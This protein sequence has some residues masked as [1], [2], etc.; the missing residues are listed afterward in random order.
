MPWIVGGAAIVGGLLGSNAT[1]SA[2]SGQADA[3]RAAT[4]EQR[5]QFDLTR[6]DTRPYRETGAAALADLAGLRGQEPSTDA[7]SVMREPGYQLGLQQGRGALEG[8]AAAR[9]GL[10]SGQALREL[11]QFGN[12]YG[13][14]KFNDSFNRQQT[15]F[16][17]R[18]NRL[19]GLAGIGQSGVNQSAAAG[20]NY[21]NQA[22]AIG[23]SNANAQGA[24]GIAQANIWGST[25][26]QL[27]SLAGRGGWGSGG[28][29]GGGVPSYAPSANYGG[30]GAWWDN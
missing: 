15:A 23:M 28:G 20:Q 12:D 30:D 10:Y 17:N 22:G 14:T 18:W 27:A 21:A 19:A 26:N 9:G 11:T 8:S 5:R 16:G 1:R 2:A 4:E 6:E 13:T 29:G 25:A 7:A 3:A 24:A